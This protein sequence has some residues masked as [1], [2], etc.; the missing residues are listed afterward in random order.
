[1]LGAGFLDD[2]RLS[3]S[4]LPLLLVLG[5]VG[6]LNAYLVLLAVAVVLVV[7]LAVIVG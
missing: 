6:V 1:M 7:A 4:W 5:V 2:P 3:P